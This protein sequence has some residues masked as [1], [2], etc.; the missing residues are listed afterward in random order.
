VD[1]NPFVTDLQTDFP[2]LVPAGFTPCPA[3]QAVVANAIGRANCNLGVIRLRNNGGTSDYNAVQ[4]EFRANNLFKQLTLRT[5]YTFAKTLDNVSEIFSTFGGANTVAFAQN[6]FNTTTAEHSFSGLDIPHQWT[7]TATEELP[8][9]KD[10]HGVVGHLLGGWVMNANYILAS[11]QRYTPSQILDALFGANGD[12]Y[13]FGFVAGFVGVDTARPFLG[14]L[15]APQTSVG[16]FCGD[17]G[18]VTG[19]SCPVGSP[20]TQLVS[21][22]ALGQ[23][24]FNFA[25]PTA[26]CNFVNVTQK[27]VRFIVNS[28]TAQSV[29]GT[30]F[31]NMPRNPVQDAITNVA[32]MSVLK[33]IKVSEHNSF[34]FRASAQ[35]VFN[36][37]NFS[38]VDP[39]VDDAGQF[40]SFTG[41]GDPKTTGSTFPG[42]NLGT[43]RFNVGL[44]FRF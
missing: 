22:T 30:P 7:I 31:G 33:R 16:V 10:Q 28:G 42:S 27:D 3:N 6:P 1:G 19:L 17:L 18:T 4:V 20:D 34:E 26:T 38:S 35:N 40:L 41:F 2:N 21:L 25:N 14:N 5:G 12:Y 8:F 36:H 39:F 32:N 43:R 29:F 13:D 11:G 24:C 9:F 44:T 15:S 23:T 37:P